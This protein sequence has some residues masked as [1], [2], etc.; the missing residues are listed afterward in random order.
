[1]LLIGIG[2]LSGQ[3]KDFEPVDL[4]LPNLH[5]E[6]SR[7]APRE[8]ILCSRNERF[9]GPHPNELRIALELELSGGPHE[10][11]LR[12]A[13]TQI[14]TSASLDSFI[15]LTK[16]VKNIIEMEKL[17]HQGRIFGRRHQLQ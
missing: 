2:S 15:S 9:E 12:H 7:H 5:G 14:A 6:E 16:R 4:P 1:M 11:G 8:C 13:A 10:A 3:N 17:Y